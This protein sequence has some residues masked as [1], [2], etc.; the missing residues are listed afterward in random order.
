MELAI[1][2]FR[3]DL[4]I[5]DNH[6][7]SLAMRSG[8]PVLGIFIF[9]QRILEPLERNDA[10]VAFIHQQLTDLDRE[11]A[12]QG[13]H[14]LVLHGEPREIWQML[15]EQYPV[16]AVYTN[17]DYEP[18]AL[19]RDEEVGSLLEAHEIEFHAVKDQVIF[20]KNDILKDNGDPYTVY[21]PYKKR[22]LSMLK[23]EH[24]K[25]YKVNGTWFDPKTTIPSLQVIGFDAPPY[26]LPDINLKHLGS[27]TEKRDIPSMDATSHL[28][29][30]LR[31]GTVSIRE[32]YREHLKSHPDFISSLIWRSFFM[33][34]LY[35]FPHVVDNAFKPAYDRIP[36][37]N[38]MEKFKRWCEGNTGYP[39]V[40][41]GMRQ[42]NNTGYMHN[43]VRMITASFLTKHLLIDWR[44]GEAYFA[45]K[46]L[47]YDLALNNGNWQW[48]AGTGCDAAPY[49]RV[50]NP[51]LQTDKFDPQHRYL[52]QW[53]PE[54]TSPSYPR[55]M[56]EHAASRTRAINTYKEALQA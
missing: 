42:L 3:R 25:E 20:S 55:P 30:H 43:R 34:I 1:H 7:L 50:F 22:F 8:I 40:D 36:W 54:Y 32:L 17:E 27:Y 44:L 2:W 6:G 33:Q 9:D 51:Y 49:F 28:G 29:P 35:H 53:V 19:E 12:K 11:I 5:H 24:Y 26:R 46:L 52:K 10:R 41:A 39:I 31:F 37:E 21:T 56:V 4:R 48:A 18:Y 45:S 38:D 15:I 13:G 16:S 47:D 23:P 14:L